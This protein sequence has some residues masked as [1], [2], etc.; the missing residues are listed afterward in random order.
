MKR[1]ETSAFDP[2]KGTCRVGD[3]AENAR[4]DDHPPPVAT[5]PYLNAV[6]LEGVTEERNESIGPMY[7]PKPKSMGFDKQAREKRGRHCR[8]F[9]EHGRCSVA[10]T[11][12]GMTKAYKE[13]LRLSKILGVHTIRNAND[14]A[15]SYASTTAA[16]ADNPGGRSSALE[17]SRNCCVESV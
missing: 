6:A 4:H 9:I 10:L 16:G 3:T 17:N 1:P 12:W 2:T 8:L 5:F 11:G 7:L 15:L 14:N 13:R